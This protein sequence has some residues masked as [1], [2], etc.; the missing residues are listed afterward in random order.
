ML[1]PVVALMLL[2]I[3]VRSAQAT[4]RC[5]GDGV[6]RTTCCCPQDDKANDDAADRETAI[7]AACCCDIELAQV[8]ASVDV[9]LEG[10]AS[11]ELATLPVVRDEWV[12]ATIRPSQTSVEPPV[13][14]RSSGPPLRLVK[15]SFLI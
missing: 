2:V 8:M 3:G 9:R 12:V 13:V 15:Q 14:H 4:Y 5:T 1:A 11:H 7:K 6:T 10:A